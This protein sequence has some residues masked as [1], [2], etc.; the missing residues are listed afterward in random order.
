[1]L[2]AHASFACAG[3]TATRAASAA[4]EAVGS[5][6]VVVATDAAVA[7]AHISAAGRIDAASEIHAVGVGTSL[8][9][10]VLARGVLRN[11]IQVPLMR[12][13]ALASMRGTSISATFTVFVTLE[14]DSIIIETTLGVHW[15][16]KT[17]TALVV[18][19]A[20]VVDPTVIAHMQLGALL[21]GVLQQ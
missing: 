11:G 3:I 5:G 2:A 10:L 13:A 16:A 9:L 19:V 21:R 20:N 14:I 7:N 15:R 12:G 1:M 4:C 17:A 6:M 8:K 18:I